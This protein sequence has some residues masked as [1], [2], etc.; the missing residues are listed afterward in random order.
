V[1]KIR[2]SRAETPAGT[3]S[4][5]PNCGTRVSKAV[6]AA[7][8]SDSIAAVPPDLDG[9]PLRIVTSGDG[10]S[11]VIYSIGWNLTDDWHGVIPR[12]FKE[13]EESNNADWPLAL[14]FPPLSPP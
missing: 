3:R 12:A 10:A 8:V 4:A 13:D 9:A 1:Q 14:P 5:C 2:A 11:A 7:L 6:P